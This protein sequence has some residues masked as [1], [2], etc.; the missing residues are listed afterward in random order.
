MQ[1]LNLEPLQASSPAASVLTDT[2]IADPT[3]ARESHLAGPS[4]A[5]LDGTI[6]DYP[7]KNL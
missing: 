4:A 7:F 5:W 2:A 1:T 6:G 3:V